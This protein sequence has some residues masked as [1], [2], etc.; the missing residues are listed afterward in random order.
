LHYSGELEDDAERA[1]IV[2]VLKPSRDIDASAAPGRAAVR[3]HP[4]SLTAIGDAIRASTGDG[5][6]LIDGAPHRHRLIPVLR[7]VSQQLV[8]GVSGAPGHDARK[9]QQQ[10]RAELSDTAHGRPSDALVCSQRTDH[11]HVSPLPEAEIADICASFQRIVVTALID[12]LFD[13]ARRHQA[14]SVGIAGVVSAN[15]RL[16][17]DLEERGRRREIPTFLPSLQ[18]STDNAAMIAAAGL[19]QFRAGI[20]APPDLNAD[21]ALAL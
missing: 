13:A 18:L 20:T 7:W 16:R 21:A 2:P 19:R 14:K 4:E 15:S 6:A 5:D 8:D 11:V 3:D 9:H 12:R 10:N 1:Q 17:A